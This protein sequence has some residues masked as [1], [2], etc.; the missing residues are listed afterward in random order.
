MATLQKFNQFTE[1][2]A[3]GAHKLNVDSL[4]LALTNILPN[5][6]NQVL[7]DITQITAAFGYP[8]GGVPVSIT[9]C[10]Q[11]A[12]VLKLVLQDAVLV[13]AGGNVGPFQYAV[14]FNDTPVSPLKPLIGWADRGTPLTLADTET[15]TFDFDPVS[16]V[17]TLT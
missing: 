12:G 8:A 15:V 4:K 17:L 14:L 3:K 5:A 1:D 10:A 7:A 9:S 2:L 11:T 13:A 16:G 6:A